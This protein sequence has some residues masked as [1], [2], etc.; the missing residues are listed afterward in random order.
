MSLFI[1]TVK[2]SKLFH[3]MLLEKGMTATV[4]TPYANPFQNGGQAINDAFT[5]LYGIDLRSMGA[6]N[7][8]FLKVT[9]P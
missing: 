7:R 2:M 9:K 1:I 6:L 5:R 3:G 8:A 4:R